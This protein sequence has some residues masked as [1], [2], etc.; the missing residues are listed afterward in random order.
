MTQQHPLCCSVQQ[1]TAAA[2]CSSTSH[3]LN[4]LRT[5]STSEGCSAT[6]SPVGCSQPWKLQCSPIATS[7]TPTLQ[8]E[9]P[10]PP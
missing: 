10:M 2:P 7:I 9:A 4:M 8:E 6:H 1:A 5:Y 3:N